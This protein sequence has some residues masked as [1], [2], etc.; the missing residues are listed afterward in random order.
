MAYTP[1]V[2]VTGATDSTIGLAQAAYDRMARFA[3]RPELYFD[4]VADIKPTN[5]SMPGSSVTFPIISDLAVASSPINES[6]DVTPQSVSESN[7]VVT[8][9]EYG[10]AVLTTAKLRGESYIEIDPI[11]ANVIGYN[12]GVSMDEVA[13]DVLKAGTNVAYAGLATSRGTVANT[14]ALKAADIR[15]AKARLRSQNVP[16][17]NGFYT[18]YI[19]P[20]VAYDFT[21]ETGSFAW[22]DPHTYSQPGEI[23]AGEMGAFEGFRF[24]ETPRSPVFNNDGSGSNSTTVTLTCVS[25][26]TSATYTNTTGIDQVGVG[27]SV[28]GLVSGTTVVAVSGPSLTSGTY[29]W[30]VTLSVAAN[31]TSGTVAVGAA[32]V[33]ATI[34]VGRQALAKA[35]SMV[36]GNTEQ[37]H[38]VPGPITDYLRRFVPWGWYWLGGYGR[39][40]EA[41]I[42]RIESGSSMNYTDPGIDQ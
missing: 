25:G 38:V 2:T 16:N 10:N 30:T 17:F 4:N 21:S 18:A 6:V 12:A 5:Q 41:A 37:P 35:W 27:D 24:I 40:R 20:N 36:D 28:S 39:Y 9:A 14:D 13:R 23:W 34:C 33:F 32:N 11:I 3:L 8:L 42:Q 22:R 31:G 29:T 19:H 7:V 26:S 15:K 1:P